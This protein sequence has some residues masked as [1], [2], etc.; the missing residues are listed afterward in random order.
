MSDSTKSTSE[1]KTSAVSARR[2]Q[3]KSG[4]IEIKKK[5]GITEAKWKKTKNKQG[6]KRTIK[7]E[8][9][10][11]FAIKALVEDKPKQIYRRREDWTDPKKSHRSEVNLLTKKLG[12]RVSEAHLSLFNKCADESE[13]GR[14]ALERAIELLAKDLGIEPK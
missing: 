14:A 3:T 10:D 7:A 5:P 8:S 4:E 2:G 6:A 1:K 12:P 13:S 9:T 11:D